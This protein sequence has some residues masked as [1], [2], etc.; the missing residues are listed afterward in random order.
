MSE[1]T[2]VTLASEDTDDHDD[3]NDHDDHASYM[4]GDQDDQFDHN[5]HGLTLFFYSSQTTQRMERGPFSIPTATS[6]L[7][8]G[9]RNEKRAMA[10]TWEFKGRMCGL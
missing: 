2:D 1:F 4:Y 7:V 9:E 10:G 5:D 3:H 8:I 6:S